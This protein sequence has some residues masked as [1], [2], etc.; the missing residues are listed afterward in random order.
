MKSYNYK[1]KNG[2]IHIVKYEYTDNTNMKLI[3]YHETKDKIVL[4]QYTEIN[5]EKKL[6]VFSED[7]K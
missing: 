3:K 1:D 7:K 4:K 2:D 5:G 6:K